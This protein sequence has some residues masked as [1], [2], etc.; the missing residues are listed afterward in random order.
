MEI[1][2]RSVLASLNETEKEKKKKKGKNRNF[3]DFFLQILDI[4]G[5]DLT[6]LSHRECVDLILRATESQNKVKILTMLGFEKRMFIE[7]GEFS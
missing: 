4:N 2:S 1:I 5:T 7:I 6:V 3:S